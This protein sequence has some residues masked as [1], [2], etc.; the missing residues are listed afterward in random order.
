MLAAAAGVPMSLLWD[1]SWELTV[2]ID[3]FWGPPHTLTY[4]SVALAG[5]VAAAL[6]GHARNAN[7]NAVRIGSLHAPLG[8]WLVMW[9][10][11]AFITAVVFDRWWQSA[12]GL[13][14]G[15]WHPP[16]LLKATSF[17]AVII[18]A[19]LLSL[20]IQNGAANHGELPGAI[21]FS[22]AGG[23]ALMLITIVMLPSS[24]PNRQH[25]ASFYKL[26]CATYPL[27][28]AALARAG[29]LRWAATAGAL[30]YMVMFC[31]SVWLLPLFPAKPQ[32]G[33]IYN[34][35]DHLM[36]PPFPL[37]LIVPALAIDRLLKKFRWPA[38]R[39]SGWLQACAS[40]AA[41]F[42]LF[43]C[44]QWIFAEFLLMNAADNWFF[45][46]GGKHWPFFLKINP[47]GRV[48]FWE[49]PSDTLTFT[50]AFIA[51]GL[52][53]IAARLGLWVGAWMARV[54]R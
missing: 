52:A 30:L 27:V 12:Y 34:A 39:G 20:T 17:F 2:G 38:W 10:A 33:P 25:S 6:A 48:A 41:F 53:V 13:G 19:W 54:R 5:I 49:S 9:G 47:A 7:P 35:M 22:V 1:F 15:I 11:L 14:A 44:A 3:R 24:Y 37:L 45:A 23:L 31:A 21:L 26:A 4:V 51:L 18:G 46:G 8:A 28:L 50:N 36:P 40:G 43:L 29:R 32:V 16:Q 42:F